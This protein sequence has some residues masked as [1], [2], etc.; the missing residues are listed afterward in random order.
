MVTVLCK[1]VQ[2]ACFMHSRGLHAHIILLDRVLGFGSLLGSCAPACSETEGTQMLQCG[3]LLVPATLSKQRPRWLPDWMKY[4]GEDDMTKASVILLSSW[5]S[6]REKLIVLCCG[7][8]S[9]LW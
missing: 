4:Q 3:C 7:E 6:H 9:A 2:N 8:M 5:L 1:D